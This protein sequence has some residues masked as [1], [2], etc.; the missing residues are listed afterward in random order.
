MH[1]VLACLELASLVLASLELACQEQTCLGLA[2]LFLAYMVV[3][4]LRAVPSDGHTVRVAH[5]EQPR[6]A[7]SLDM[8]LEMVQRQGAVA[9][10]WWVRMALGTRPRGVGWV[11][12]GQSGQGSSTLASSEREPGV[13]GVGMSPCCLEI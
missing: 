2:C 10:V 3:A 9:Q 6:R 8:A 4:C 1:R 7:L 11:D 13:P 12:R 5:M